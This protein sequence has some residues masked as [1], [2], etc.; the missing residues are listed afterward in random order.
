VRSYFSSGCKKFITP[1]FRVD[2]SDIRLQ[3]TPLPL[4]NL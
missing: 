3:A 1:S 4:G 2:L